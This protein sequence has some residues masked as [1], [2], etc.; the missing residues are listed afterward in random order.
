MLGV[1][2][3]GAELSP[4]WRSIGVGQ[5]RPTS[6]RDDLPE[7]WGAK[8]ARRDPYGAP[9]EQRFQI[10]LV[11]RPI[12]AMVDGAPKYR[13]LRLLTTGVE[14]TGISCAIHVLAGL[15]WQLLGPE[16]ASR[17]YAPAGSRPLRWRVRRPADFYNI[18]RERRRSTRSSI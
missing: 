14:G 6:R 7:D 12:K 3:R 10:A 5:V 1:G 11:I 9:G 17:F 18:I 2:F 8:E 13:P 15:A 4:N 16:M